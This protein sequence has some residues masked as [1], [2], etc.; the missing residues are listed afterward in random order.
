MIFE[1][2]LDFYT[3]SDCGYYSTGQDKKL[4]L[5]D[6]RSTLADLHRWLN[7]SVQT[8]KDSQTFTVD[9]K[10]TQLPV[11]G[12]SMYKDDTTKDYLLV[13]W[14]EN[15][16]VD[17]KFAAVHGDQKPGVAEVDTQLIPDKSIPGFPTYF[18]F[19]TNE[20]MVVT[21][22]PDNR[23]N[24]HQGLIAYINGFLQKFSQWVVEEETDNPIQRNIIG[25][26]EPDNDELHELVKPIYHSK[27]LRKD[28]KLNKIRGSVDKIRKIIQKDTYTPLHS[29]KLGVVYPS[30]L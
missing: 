14:N 3:I 4:V 28:G 24:G 7:H 30:S 15:E 22:R 11:Y 13:T 8:V 5:A 27:L 23:L 17:G 20:N 9:K 16:V 25:Y 19:I 12:Y 10:G 29:Q 2:K 18:W 1:V 26:K 21:V 6:L